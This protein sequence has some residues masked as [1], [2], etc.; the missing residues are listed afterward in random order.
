MNQVYENLGQY[1]EA[2]FFYSL[3]E[4]E[5]KQQGFSDF[6]KP[7]EEKKDEKKEGKDEKNKKPVDPKKEQMQKEQAIAEKNGMDTIKKM[8]ENFGRM[9]SAAG[10]KIEVFKNF[11]NRQE[12]AYMAIKSKEP[13]VQ[14]RK[15][16]YAMYD[17][18]FLVLVKNTNG[19]PC[20]VVVKVNLGE[21]EENPFFTCCSRVV[22]KEF[23]K[24]YK[25][26]VNE[27]K[28]IKVNY[29]KTVEAKIKEEEAKKQKEKL[30]KFLKES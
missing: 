4:A 29:Q 6:N 24:F 26:M 5:K 2:T 19:K 13:S 8:R 3:L 27:L 21:G 30:D 12:E 22:I 10:S 17:S 16:V 11:W 23:R 20:L 7:A 28:Q 1:K 25:E 15:D 9:K 14:N 18:E